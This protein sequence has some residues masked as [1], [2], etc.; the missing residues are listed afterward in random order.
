MPTKESLK[1]REK[2]A[3]DLIREAPRWGNATN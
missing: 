2:R 3:Q 1:A